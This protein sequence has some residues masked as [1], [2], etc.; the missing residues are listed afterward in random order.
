MYHMAK[1]TVVLSI[2]ARVAALLAMLWLLLPKPGPSEHPWLAQPF[3]DLSIDVFGGTKSD[4]RCNY[5]FRFG[6]APKT[7]D[8]T[9]LSDVSLSVRKVRQTY[10]YTATDHRNEDD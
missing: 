7:L 3:V 10:G 4:Y 5:Y 6:D 8:F 1:K 9:G 2:I